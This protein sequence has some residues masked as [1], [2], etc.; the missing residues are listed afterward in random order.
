MTPSETSSQSRSSAGRFGPRVLADWMVYGK[1]WE[2]KDDAGAPVRLFVPTNTQPL[3]NPGEG[4][5]SV[6]AFKELRSAVRKRSRSTRWLRPLGWFLM[7]YGAF[8]LVQDISTGLGGPAV[9]FPW[10]D[11]MFHAFVFV[12]GYY[13]SV[14]IG[15]D[16]DAIREALRANHRCASCGYDISGTPASEDGLI[17]CPECTARWKDAEGANA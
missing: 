11:V 6:K 15:T 4:V 14:S 12:F 9:L 5:M 16:R 13:L 17:C 8:M 3:Q 2:I 10:R 7:L 1:R